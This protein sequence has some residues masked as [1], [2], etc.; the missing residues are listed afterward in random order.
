VPAVVGSGM[1][2][3]AIIE[4]NYRL[5]NMGKKNLSHKEK[6]ALT[7]KIYDFLKSKPYIIFAYIFGSFVSGGTFNDIDIGIYISEEQ[8][9][10]PL[11]LELEAELQALLRQQVDIRIINYAPVSFVYNILKSKI[12]ILD[13]DSDLRADF[14]GLTYKKYFDFRHLR[15]EYLRGVA[16]API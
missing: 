4:G 3:H 16:G 11:S 5:D 15:D 6:E 14:E 7:K 8:D 10:S 13:A 9:S 1:L 2:E 12:L